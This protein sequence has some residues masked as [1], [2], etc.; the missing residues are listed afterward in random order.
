MAANLE[1]QTFLRRI[2]ILQR[3]PPKGAGV[4][5]AR[6]LTE[7]LKAAG[8][9]IEK[10]TVER[11]LE[12]LLLHGDW[13]GTL[14]CDDRSKPF[15]W[16]IERSTARRTSLGLTVDEALAFAWI[17]RYGAELLPQGMMQSLA[18][19]F[20]EADARLQHDQRAQAWLQKKVRMVAARPV[21]GP[22]PASNA[23][24]RAVRLALYED[25]QLMIQ[26]RNAQG[27]SNQMT[28]SPLALVSRDLNLYLV[29][30]IPR[31]ANIRVLHASRILAAKVKDDK[32]EAPPHFDIDAYIA[33]GPFQLGGDAQ[34]V[35]LRFTNFAGHA[36][37]D[38]PIAPDQQVHLQDE[39]GTLELS[40]TVR[41]SPQF[42]AWLLGYG[43]SVQVLEPLELRQDMAQTLR[44]TMQLYGGVPS[45]TRGKT[46]AG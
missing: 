7:Q 12:F 31:F 16:S 32:A 20:K 39:G 33:Q 26:Y 28:V 19:F 41:L 23:V 40:A 6:D 21:A 5:N 14:H 8:Y 45:T 46:R 17:G 34:R 11:D 13:F 10:R 4:I 2:E 35:Q 18:P 37:L 43:V 38:A 42:K 44:E 3:L 30:W 24:M 1:A 22:K 27:D 36:L 15:G 29:V 25:V 9:P